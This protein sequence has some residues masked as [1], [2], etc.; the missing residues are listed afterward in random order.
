[1]YKLSSDVV[2][3]EQKHLNIYTSLAFRYILHTLLRRERGINAIYWL[4]CSDVLL[5]GLFADTYEM[6]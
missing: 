3:W 1:M 4:H 2:R 6:C 5:S